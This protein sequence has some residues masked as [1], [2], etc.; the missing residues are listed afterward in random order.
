MSMLV[1]AILL[2]VV[3]KVALS[4]LECPVRQRGGLQSLRLSQNN[5]VGIVVLAGITILCTDDLDRT[6]IVCGGVHTAEGDL[7]VI[8]TS[9]N[10]KILRLRLI[11]RKGVAG[12]DNT[13]IIRAGTSPSHNTSS[14]GW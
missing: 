11:C 8:D 9:E 10:M 12:T 13:G 2:L 6:R 1:R 4:T 14:S 3:E 7:L 5:H